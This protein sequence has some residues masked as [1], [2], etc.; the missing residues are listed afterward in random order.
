MRDSMTL[1]E[2]NAERKRQEIMA[3]PSWQEFRN[4]RYYGEH[5]FFGVVDK[6]GNWVDSAV[7]FHAALD[8]AIQYEG[9]APESLNMMLEKA[10]TYKVNV[11]HSSLLEKMYDA[12]LLK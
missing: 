2:A 1:G 12:G 4:T 11:I 10:N 5:E 8:F 3:K 6:D 7:Q 9:A